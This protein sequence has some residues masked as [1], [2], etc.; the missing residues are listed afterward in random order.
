M[1]SV[2]RGLNL[3]PKLCC[4]Q[5]LWAIISTRH[6]SKKTRLQ[7][8]QSNHGSKM[9]FLIHKTLELRASRNYQNRITYFRI[10]NKVY[11][12]IAWIM[13]FLFLGTNVEAQSRNN[14]A[15]EFDYYVMALSWSP[16][17]CST[18]GNP[19]ES[20]C[21]VGKR[22]G[23]V[24]HGLW[25][26]YEKGWPSFC[27]QVSMPESAQSRYPDLY[28]AQKLYRHEWDKHGTC[29]GLTPERYLA[30]SQRLKTALQIPAAYRQP[31][32]PFRTTLADLKRAF[33]QSNPSFPESA[34]A[35]N[36]SGSGR[37]LQE[38]MVCY[39]KDGRPRSCSQEVLRRSART[40]G[41]PDFLVR[42]VR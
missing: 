4:F 14:R 13:L 15:G 39:E 33:R 10:M 38:V 23:L 17:Y 37:F 36:C 26:Q 11:L 22:L 12:Q 6:R 3:R 30:L 1:F 19:N 25:P 20:Q 7:S 29:S 28:P 42:S 31:A 35:P 9:P 32:Q 8:A 34:F 21:Q 2:S 24:L 18:Q 27:S 41:K 5:T 40:C 16:D